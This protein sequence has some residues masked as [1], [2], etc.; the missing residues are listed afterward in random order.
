[1]GWSLNDLTLAS[2]AHQWA[3]MRLDMYSTPKARSMSST[4]RPTVISTSYDRLRFI[5]DTWIVASWHQTN[6]LARGPC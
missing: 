4:W 5:C 1:M 6:S 2:G 3:A